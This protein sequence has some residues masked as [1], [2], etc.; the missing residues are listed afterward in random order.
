MQI[1]G[2]HV[3]AFGKSLH[4]GQSGEIVADYGS[5]MLVKA[6]DESYSGAH[7]NTIGP[8]KY[9]QVDSLLFKINKAPNGT[10]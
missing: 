10:D 5:H 8:G 2:C 3:T 4:C 1:I 6:D 7:K 9:F